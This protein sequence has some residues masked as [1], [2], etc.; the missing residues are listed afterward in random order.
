MTIYQ[1]EFKSTML[2][3]CS[4]NSDTQELTVTFQNGKDYIYKEVSINTYTDL[5]GAK[6]AG[7]YFSSIKKDLVQK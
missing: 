6:S 3:N 7:A 5:I 2:A 1:H 4:Y